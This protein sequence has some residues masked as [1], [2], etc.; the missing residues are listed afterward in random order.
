MATVVGHRAVPDR[1][2]WI[3]TGWELLLGYLCA[4]VLLL[5]P[6]LNAGRALRPARWPWPLLGGL[7]VVALVAAVHPRVAPGP[8]FS[9]PVALIRRSSSRWIASQIA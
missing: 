7:F 1:P 4:A 8:G 2:G 6:A 3:R 5:V 9:W